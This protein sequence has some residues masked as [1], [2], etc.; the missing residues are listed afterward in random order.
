[1]IVDVKDDGV[2][3]QKIQYNKIQDGT[4]TDVRP[5]GNDDE[6]HRQRNCKERS[7]EKSRRDLRLQQK[8]T[9]RTC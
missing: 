7:G 4:Q 3:E 1:M 9:K 6:M 5:K 8:K 2:D